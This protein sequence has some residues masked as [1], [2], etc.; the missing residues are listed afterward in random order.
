MNALGKDQINLSPT[1]ERPLVLVTDD[2]EDTRLLFRTLLEMR[3]CAVIEA[4]D[5]EQ[6]VQLA[7]AAV[8]DLILMDGTLPRLDGL[9]ATRRIRELNQGRK[10]PIV[11]ICGRAEPG[12]DAVA[13]NAGCDDFLLKPINFE[14][15]FNVL[16]KHLGTSQSSATEVGL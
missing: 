5:G 7:E 4:A 12:Y 8:P 13:T 10:I 1:R 3:G 16:A 6:G 14:V 2:H 9:N 15:F 11:L